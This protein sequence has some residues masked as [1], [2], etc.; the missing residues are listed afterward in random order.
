M[1]HSLLEKTGFTHHNP[2]D[3]SVREIT[4]RGGATARL[5]VHSKSGHGI[6]DPAHW[7][8]ETYYEEEYRKEFSA[9]SDGKLVEAARH[10]EIYRQLNTRQ[11]AQ[12]S[13][14]LTA[15]THYLEVGCSFGGVLSQV[16]ALGVAVCHG[17]EPN[18]YDARFVMKNVP[19]AQVFNTLLQDADLDG[20]GYDVICSFEVME[21]VPSPR[22]FIE[23][24]MP[25]L[26]PGGVVN[27]EVPNHHD[28]LLKH[29]PM[30]GYENFYYHEAHIHF[31]THPSLHELFEQCGFSGE[32][33]SFLMYPFFN[34]VYWQQNCGPQPSASMAHATP[35]PATVDNS[36][37]R[38]INAFYRRVEQEYEALVNQHMVGD[39]LVYQGR[40]E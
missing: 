6:L 3:Y 15:N 11:L 16:A 40:K 9:E 13:K 26:K 8:S 2:E 4:L 39:C 31:F 37:G 35:Q 12:F 17:V 25:V 27:I 19:S 24:I 21:H 36:T 33:S 34:N 28:V 22:A 30:S 29:Y 32:V 5:W 18:R 23:T 1:D 7:V 10:F 38:A 20:H 14:F